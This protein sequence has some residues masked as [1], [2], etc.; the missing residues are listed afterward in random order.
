MAAVLQSNEGLSVDDT[1]QVNV[2]VMRGEESGG[3]GVKRKITNTQLFSADCTIKKKKSMI[4]I[5]EVE[6][7]YLCAARAVVT[8][9]AKLLNEPSHKFKMLIH[10][11]KA[12][13]RA[14]DSQRSRAIKLHMDACVATDRPVPVRELYKFEELLDV[15]IIVIS[16]D[17]DNEII[18]TGSAKREKKI[19]LYLKD[20][21]FHS[22]ININGFYV[23]KKMCQ[24]CLTVY[25]KNF[26][27]SCKSVCATCGRTGCFFGND[28]VTCGDCNLVC[29][30]S[31]CF[32]QHKEPG[33]HKVGARKGEEIPSACETFFRCS[34]C[35]RT[36]DKL[37]RDISTHKC[38]EWYCHCCKDYVIGDHLCYYRARKPRLTSGKFIFFDFESS[39][40]KIF[41]CHQGY[42]SKPKAGC[43]NCLPTQLCAVCRRCTNCKKGY[44]GLE[45]HTPNFLVCQSACDECKNDVFTPESKCAHCGDRCSKCFSTDKNKILPLCDNGICGRRELIFSGPETTENFCNWLIAP[46]HHSKIVMAHNGRSYDFQFILSHCVNNGIFPEIIYTGSKITTMKIGEGVGLRFIDSLNF[47]PMALKKLPTALGLSQGL[48]KGEFP[49]FMNT[50]ENQDY[51]GPFPHESYFGVDTMST[52]NRENFLKW[53]SEQKDRVFDFQKEILEYTRSDVSILREACTKFRDLIIEM[54]T[55]KDSKVPGVDPFAFSTLAASCMQIIRLL[56]IYEEHDVTLLDGRC[57]RA[58]LRRGVWTFEG[59]TIDESQI[60]HSKFIKSPIP[61]IPA[62]GYGKHPKDSNKAAIWLE[63]VSRVTCRHIKHSRNS[64]EFIVPGTSYHVDGFHSESNTVYEFLGCRWHG[65]TC[66]KNRTSRDPRTKLSIDTLLK[67]TENRL[68]EIRQKGFTVV[69]LWECE[70]DKMLKSDPDFKNFADSY[71]YV[72]PLKI[73]SSFFGGRVSP[74]KL[75]YEA[76]EDEKIH[77]FD[78][79]SLYPFINY[80]SKYPT[81]HPEIIT[82]SEAF[83]Y[84]LKS[85]FGLVKLK[86]VPPRG[87]Y[88]PVLPFRCNNRL[89]FPL[90]RTCAINQATCDCHCDDDSRALVGTFVINEVIEAVAQKYRIVEIYEIYNYRET[91]HDNPTFGGIFEHYVTMFMRMKAQATGFPDHVVTQSDKDRFVREY[92]EKQGIL[93]DVEKIVK[94]P[95]LRLISKLHLN[96]AWGKFV[97]QS[98]LIQTTYVKSRAELARLRCDPTLNISDFHLIN[99]NYIVVEFKNSETFEEENTFTNEIIGTFTTAYAR[100]HLL[101]IL[102]KTGRNTLYFDTDSVIFVQKDNAPPVLE[103]G[104][105]LGDLTDELPSGVHI[106]TFLSSGPK[107]YCFKQSD[108]KCV[109]R[110]KGITLNY[111][112]DAVIDFESMKNIVVGNA[113]SVKLPPSKQINR[114]KHLGIV[115][116]RPQSKVFKKVF[117]KRVIIPGTFDSVPYGY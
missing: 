85:Y 102:Q 67:N 73:R 39:Q 58:F 18:Y 51:V 27:H 47:L 74:T 104:D 42:V 34:K 108:E 72:T 36:I 14:P 38:G 52:S 77:Y 101:K 95:S 116:N 7:E 90:C 19:F 28:S 17:L 29:R 53:H 46:Q 107:S 32:K 54:T 83:D 56:M 68:R 55:M 30:N 100:L 60:A 50:S 103:T 111:L 78:V 109:T 63:W 44:C 41:E 98:N 99:E 65:H 5:P 6:G 79:T 59:Q 25:N 22:I 21:H 75:F 35:G 117:T 106:N 105:L 49:H 66:M 4:F 86:I 15:Q 96:A 13:S 57:G 110:I 97:Q 114:V 40:E 88:I 8:C 24:E 43:T 33:E 12:T 82:N 70:F 1:F 9:M 61:Q 115:Y 16:G 11:D 45:R 23:N 76:K 37:K 62:Q 26:R 64:D 69:S 3:G 2:G 71:D 87:L 92:Y 81:C 80:S 93:L 31:E 48:K 91:T 10:K 20:D 89:L 94:N 113:H 84:S 112:N